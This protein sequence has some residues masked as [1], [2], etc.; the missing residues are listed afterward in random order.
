M[1]V[2]NENVV[3]FLNKVKCNTEF[4]DEDLILNFTESGVRI[5][6]VN[7]TKTVVLTANLSKNAFIEYEQIGKIGIQKL[8]EVISVLRTFGDEIELKVEGNLL[9]IKERGRK[10]EI[11]LLDINMILEAPELKKEMVFSENI[12]LT[13]KDVN[14]FLADAG[15]NK[16]FATFI[17][18]EKGKII[19]SN[20]GK[21]KFTKEIDTNDCVGGNKLKLGE[22]FVNV[23][24]AFATNIIVGLGAGMPLKII[25]KS[26]NSNISVIVAPMELE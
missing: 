8:G 5:N 23:M 11:E 24:K 21:Y 18:T 4:S 10:V 26:D 2:K 22:P 17:T 7:A 20:T 6:A 1:K 9:I 3:E 13:G 12:T 16:E 19:F 25:E 15:M 14:A